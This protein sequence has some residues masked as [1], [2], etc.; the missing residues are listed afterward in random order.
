MSLFKRVKSRRAAR[1]NHFIP[2]QVRWDLGR[3]GCLHNGEVQIFWFQ[4]AT[5]QLLATS[6]TQCS[7][8]AL[9]ILHCMKRLSRAPE[10]TM[11]LNSAEERSRDES[12]EINDT[13]T[14]QRFSAEFFNNDFQYELSV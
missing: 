2:V 5:E 7:G 3:T 8:V 13:K 11:K 1:L 9:H 14:R 12:N 4:S 6:P 10:C